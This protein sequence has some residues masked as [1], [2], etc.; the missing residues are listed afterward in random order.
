MRSIRF[1]NVCI[2]NKTGGN[3]YCIDDVFAKGYVIL[4]REEKSGAGYNPRTDD[5]AGGDRYYTYQSVVRPSSNEFAQDVEIS[6]YPAFGFAWEYAKKNGHDVVCSPEVNDNFINCATRDNTN[7]YT[8][9]FAD[10]HNT[11]DSVITKN[12]TKGLCALMDSEFIDKGFDSITSDGA[13]GLD[14]NINSDYGCVMSDCYDLN[15]IA[16]KF[17]LSTER[18]TVKV[19]GKSENICA[20]HGLE[21]VGAN[22]VNTY[23]GYEYMSYAFR[24]I[25]TVMEPS[26]INI[27]NA[28]IKAQGINVTSFT[29]DYNPI[30]WRDESKIA[31]TSVSVSD[32]NLLRCQLNGK[33]VDCVFDDL[34][35]SKMSARIIGDTGMK[36]LLV[37]REKGG[38]A[39][40][41]GKY[42]KGPNESQCVELGKKIS[43]G[44]RWDA[45]AG[46]CLLKDAAAVKTL[47]ICGEM[48][49][50][51]DE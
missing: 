19:N 9:K 46:A 48:S 43:G 25:Q 44:T 32:D 2:G 34:F 27:L 26:L 24:E 15:Q 23:P 39:S 36:C 35:E 47:I 1:A 22:V 13:M 5:L 6:E 17:G 51:N 7:F 37:N 8:F 50:I 14:I 11:K 16:V 12:L 3:Q 31:G 49:N 41:D 28:Y 10:T 20:I 42:C 18:K 38:T 29:C 33:S 30:K 4:G 21:L 45:G 40:F